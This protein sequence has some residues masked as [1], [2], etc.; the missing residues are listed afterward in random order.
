MYKFKEYIKE[1]I[2]I[3][4]APAYDGPVG[5]TYDAI[6]Y[7][8][9]YDNGFDVNIWNVSFVKGHTYIWNVPTSS[10]SKDRLVALSLGNDY[11]VFRKGIQ[12][13]GMAALGE[14]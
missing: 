14:K 8:P 1:E 3:N 12:I 2:K 9:P 13:S 7:S 11:K 6:A 10:A 5:K 4:T